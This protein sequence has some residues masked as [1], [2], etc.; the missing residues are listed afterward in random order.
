[1]RSCVISRVRILNICEW[2]RAVGVCGG[3]CARARVGHLKVK[4]FKYMWA[5]SCRR[6]VG[7]CVQH[8]KGKNYKYMW[9]ESGRWCVCVCVCARARAC[10]PA[11]II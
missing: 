8:L 4:N 11:C 7:A 1:M 5:E 3:V 6:C 2:N 9:A 10:V